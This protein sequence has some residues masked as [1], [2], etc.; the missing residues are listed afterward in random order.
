MSNTS[1]RITTDDGHD[2]EEG[3][4]GELLVKGPMVSNG[5]WENEQSTKGHVHKRWLVQDRGHW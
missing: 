2:V 1:L 4:P 5:Y 3:T